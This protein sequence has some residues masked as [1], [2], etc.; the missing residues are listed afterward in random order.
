[1]SPNSKYELIGQSPAMLNLKSTLTRFAKSDAAVLL[2]GESGSGK[3]LCAR[4]LHRESLVSKGPFVAVNC[5]A[6]APELIEAELF[7]TRSGAFTGARTRNGFLAQ[8]EG[9]TLFLDEIGDLPAST[10]AV[11]LRVL[12]TREY[13]PVGS[14]QSVSMNVRIVS[15]THKPLQQLVSQG[16]FRIDLY[17]RLATVV[18]RIPPLRQHLEDLPLLAESLIGDAARK[19]TAPAWKKLQQHQWPGNVRELRNTLNR[20]LFE[21]DGG[22]ITSQHLFL[23]EIYVEG[24][25]EKK[26][27]SLQEHI[28]RFIIDSV[29]SHGGNVR[30]AARAIETSP[31]TIYRYLALS[32]QMPSFAALA[33]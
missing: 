6:I 23:Q 18:V 16:K 32:E 33:Q 9:G 1:M 31:T 7:G 15:A 5:A 17:H 13:Y 28:I 4:T 24:V 26:S 3:E 20:A 21:A 29:K 25:E 27:Q 8:A 22:P 19:I 30:A 2:L 12:E 11:L 14:C 10:Q